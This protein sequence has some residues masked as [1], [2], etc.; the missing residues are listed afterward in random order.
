[1]S[2]KQLVHLSQV[3]GP[4]PRY[5]A[6][7]LAALEA[8]SAA[9]KQNHNHRHGHHHDTG[10]PPRPAKSPR[11]FGPSVATWPPPLPPTG[12]KPAQHPLIHQSAGA[13]PR[14]CGSKTQRNPRRP[15]NVAI[16]VLKGQICFNCI[17]Q[18]RSVFLS[19]QLLIILIY[20]TI[21]CPLHTII[22]YNYL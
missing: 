10:P 14:P 22:T 12:G 13:T 6:A 2:T 9:T 11:S 18:S 20:M 8:P 15:R 7:M 4:S 17:P 21:T 16:N 3:I 19:I 5:R 1:M